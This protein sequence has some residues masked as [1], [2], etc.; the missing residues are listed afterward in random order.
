MNSYEETAAAL[1]MQAAGDEA[2]RR[3]RVVADQ[4][5]QLLPGLTV[6]EAISVLCLCAGETL[7]LLPRHDVPKALRNTIQAI[8][9]HAAAHPPGRK[10]WAE[11]IAVEDVTHA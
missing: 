5:M 11:Q 3:A 8:A 9:A 1:G 7:A 10:R 6:Q 4:I 2:R